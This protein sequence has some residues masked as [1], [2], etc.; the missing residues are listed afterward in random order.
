MFD[1]TVCTAR[2]LQAH[3]PEKNFAFLSPTLL[4]ARWDYATLKRA[5][6]DL[7]L[8]TE[9]ADW[10]EIATKLS[11]YGRWEYEDYRPSAS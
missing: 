3:P 7:C 5:L 9:G 1:F 8:H 6:G 10:G 4:M 11:R 2:W